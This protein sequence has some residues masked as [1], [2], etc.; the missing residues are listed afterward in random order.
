MSAFRKKHSS[1]FISLTRVL[2]YL[3]PDAAQEELLLVINGQFHHQLCLVAAKDT[4]HSLAVAHFIRG[5]SLFILQA[6][7]PLLNFMCKADDC[8]SGIR[9]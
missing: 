3:G 1:G 7:A 9:L 4:Q 6:P 8:K 5:L 2:P